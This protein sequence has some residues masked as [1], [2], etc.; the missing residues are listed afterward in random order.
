VSSDV[1]ADWLVNQK[2]HVHFNFGISN[3]LQIYLL[4]FGVGKKEKPLFNKQMYS[5]V[6][7]QYYFQPN[8]KVGKTEKY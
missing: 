7:C 4:H 1:P 6:I 5:M 2:A 8:I 3:D